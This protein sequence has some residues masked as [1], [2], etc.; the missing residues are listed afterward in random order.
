MLID[1]QLW[2]FLIH[3][4]IIFVDAIVGRN[5]FIGHRTPLSNSDANVP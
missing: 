2:R 3:R 5:A 1:T 4:A